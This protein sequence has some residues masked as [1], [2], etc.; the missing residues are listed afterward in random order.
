MEG[1]SRASRSRKLRGRKRAVEALVCLV[2]GGSPQNAPQL[3]SGDLESGIMQL[4]AFSAAALTARSTKT[5]Q[6]MHRVNIAL[7]EA[8]IRLFEKHS[9]T[10]RAP[11]SRLA[12]CEQWCAIVGF[13]FHVQGSSSGVG[14]PGEGSGSNVKR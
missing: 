13:V 9:A 3:R 7:L 1:P 2:A 8:A 11:I 14:R 6:R 10:V 4:T 5:R 12:R